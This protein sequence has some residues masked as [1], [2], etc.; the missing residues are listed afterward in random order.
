MNKY[1]SCS[2][3]E[4]KYF[5]IYLGH[6][7]IHIIEILLFI[8]IGL[9]KANDLKNFNDH[10][11][12]KLFITYFGMFLCII[13]EIILKL[14]TKNHKS[15]EKNI[16]KNKKLKGPIMLIY[17]DLSDKTTFKDYIYIGLASFLL[18]VIDFIKIF[19]EKKEGSTNSEYYFATLPFLLF[20]SIY[21]Y[22][23]DFYK[24][25][26]ISIII[27]TI[28]GIYEYIIKLNHYYNNNYNFLNII[29][30]FILQ[31]LI[32]LG[33]A[34]FFSYIK[35]LMNYKFF[36]PYKVCYIF[37]S[38]NMIIILILLFILSGIKCSN[39]DICKIKYNNN[40]YFDNIYIIF[41]NIYAYQIFIIILIS[42]LLGTLKLM[43]NLIINYYS[44]CHIFL[45]L[46]NNG[47]IDTI[48]HE[49]FNQSGAF[50][51]IT[52]G[53]AHFLNFFFSAVFLEI[54]ELK[55]CGLNK[56]YKI[57]IIK[58]VDE[59]DN[60]LIS[61]ENGNEEENEEQDNSLINDNS[62]G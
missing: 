39:N 53:I 28:F 17:N 48:K 25:Q 14:K 19:L 29:F 8:N 32:G 60:H 50:I 43:I 15:E 52:H 1:I 12:F 36:S 55:F 22:K 7:F 51:Q 37:G 40:F 57:N 38:I 23:N 11:V 31:I 45:F 24:H 59:E 34:I 58:R 16:N 33:D 30:D 62:Q 18:L 35:G 49:F 3:C 61:L 47:V 21:F 6:I 46:E 27:I 5:L 41:Q 56:N 26:Y 44:V 10:S 4:K 2:K 20:I 9:F 13:P 42:I 54:I